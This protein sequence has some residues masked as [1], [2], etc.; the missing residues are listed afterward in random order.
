L[1]RGHLCAL[2][3]KALFTTSPTDVT[4]AQDLSSGYAKAQPQ[5]KRRESSSG[6]KSHPWLSAQRRCP[7]SRLSPPKLHAKAIALFYSHCRISD[8]TWKAKSKAKPLPDMV[9]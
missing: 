3:A 7:L 1:H 5:T 9:F 4:L 2:P 6:S 8:G